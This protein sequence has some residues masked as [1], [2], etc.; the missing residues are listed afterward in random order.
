MTKRAILSTIQTSSMRYCVIK[1][2]IL[3]RRICN[4]AVHVQLHGFADASKKAYGA[5]VYLRSVDKQ[6]IV[7]IHLLCSKSKVA[8][9]KTLTIPRLE[10]CVALLLARLVNVV[11]T[12]L[13]LTIHEIYLWSDST[14]VL[15]WLQTPETIM[16]IF[17]ASRAAEIL[18]LNGNIVWKHVPSECNPADLISRDVC[19][20]QIAT[21]TRWWH[22]PV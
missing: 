22:G 19:L 1:P 20:S 6:G 12:F 9:L 16:K 8:S 13:R 18:E 17:V 4:N 11:L 21:E 2:K 7:S 14:I 15:S 10:L 5:C 3:I